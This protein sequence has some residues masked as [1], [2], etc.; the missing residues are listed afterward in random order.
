MSCPESA[1]EPQNLAE[2]CFL[3]EGLLLQCLE[4]IEACTQTHYKDPSYAPPAVVRLLD[5]LRA[6]VD[7]DAPPPA[8]AK[9]LAMANAM[10]LEAI[11]RYAN[12]WVSCDQSRLVTPEMLHEKWEAHWALLRL[13]DVE[14]PG[15]GR[16]GAR[17]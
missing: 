5:D 2:L 11:R 14:A 10:L 15:Q 6:H 8:D 1:T 9:L 12:G 7:P 17:G 3:Q 16:E 13:V 4:A